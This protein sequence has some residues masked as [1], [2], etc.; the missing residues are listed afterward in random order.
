MD[1]HPN[2]EVSIEDQIATLTLNRPEAH[3]ALNRDMIQAL[4]TALAHLSQ[5]PE[6]RLLH[7]QAKGKTFC[8]G[9]DLTDMQAM[10]HFNYE[11]NCAEAR[12]LGQVFY[13]LYHFPT[14]VL[15]TV[16]G[17]AYGGGLGLIACA[18]LVI[19]SETAQ[20]CFS[21]TKLGLV[22]ALISPYIIQAIGERVAKRYFLTADS[23]SATEAKALGLIHEVVPA[24]TV[25]TLSQ[26][27]IIQ[28]NQNGP[29][30]LR[31]TKALVRD[32][33]QKPF[34]DRIVNQTVETLAQIRVSTEG[35]EGLKAFLEK[36]QPNWQ[37]T[38]TK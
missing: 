34:S 22:P 10:A 23:F 1:I 19:A 15:I 38:R 4:N 5:A 35:Q 8:A 31:A 28:L 30:A 25:L 7:L 12:A 27:W 20:F 37:L 33:S 6:I 32:L 17:S 21:E 18:D 11:E 14:P 26:Q 16:Q 2:V 3:N 29:Q 36:R 24:T 13:Q 9:A